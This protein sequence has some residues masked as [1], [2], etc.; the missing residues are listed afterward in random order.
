VNKIR[1]Y[2]Y[3]MYRDSLY[4]A[5]ADSLSGGQ[6]PI[7]TVIIGTDPVISRYLTISGDL[8]T[9]G[10]D[11]DV[12]IVSTLDTRM[13]G[14]IAITFGDMAANSSEPTILGFG[15]MIWSS[16]MVIGT[17]LTRNGAVVRELA[18]SP[19]FI[20]IPNLPVLTMLTVEGIEDVFASVPVKFKDVL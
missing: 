7:P 18:V 8:R 9:L 2:A 17:A 13:R 14:R 16:E 15:N 10:N 12:R 1:D 3:R 6:A 5:A 11:F 4:K 19:R 20:H